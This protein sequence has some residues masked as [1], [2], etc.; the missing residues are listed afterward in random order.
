MKWYNIKTCLGLFL[1]QSALS[2]CQTALGTVALTVT[3]SAVSNTYQGPITLQVTGL[4]G[5]DSVVVQKFL[6]LNA[7]GTV[8]AADMLV[9]QFT[10]TDGQAGMVIGGV[11]NLNV[12]GDVDTAAGQITAKLRFP[13]GDFVQSIV[14]KYLFKVSGN[15]TPPLTND[16]T[17]T[18]FPYAQSIT[19]SVVSNNTST[20]IS[21]AVV[22]L[23]PSPRGGNHGPGNPVAAA[24]ADNSGNYH[25]QA[26][27]GTY[28]PLAF[29][30]NFVADYPT[31]PL[32]TLNGAQTIT[33][34]LTLSAAT[35][36]ISGQVVD[37]SNPGIGLPGIFLPAVSPSGLIAVAFP[38]TNG[39]FYA[40]VEPGTWNLEGAPAGL[41]LHG[42]VGY[43][44]GLNVSAGSSVTNGFPKATAL[45]YGR[46]TDELGNPLSAIDVYAN[47]NNGQFQSDGY[48]DTNGYYEV[49]ALGGLSGDG[50]YAEV[51]TGGGSGNPTNYI[52]SQPAFDQTGGASLSVNQ[53]VLVNFTA[54]V[55]TNVLSGNVQFGGTNVAGVGVFATA[56]IGGVTFNAY[57]DTDANGNYAF[58]VG[59][60]NWSVN[61]NCSGGNDSLDNI[62]G[63][64]TYQC[65]NN[66]NVTIN[67]NNAT[68]NFAV[69]PPG[70]SLQIST[71][72]L[73]NANVG[74]PYSAPL[75][76]SGGTMPYNWSLANGSLPLPSGLTLA[77]NGVI[78]GIPET[79]G[80]F[81]FTVQ[82]T[83]ASFSSANQSL[84]LIINPKPS[85]GAPSRFAGQF[86][87]LLSGGANQNYTIQTSTNLA[88]TNWVS[89]YV[90]NNPSSG[91]FVIRVPDATNSRGF[92]RIVVGP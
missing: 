92:Y 23:F 62:L 6:D 64:G 32:L 81:N 46:V 20:T 70:A 66:Q 43:Q 51:S 86:Q 24:V 42:Y 73:P 91:S 88:S 67:N 30:P 26:P 19:G 21:D 50:W 8:D 59:N 85:L 89:L 38:D 39:N 16:F 7:N 41:I 14:G 36:A 4:A 90:T 48:S 47:D 78:A 72:S 18:N 22:I 37:L 44:S 77:T 75:Q 53:A 27:T 15:F 74:A 1:I 68:A 29:G 54:L 11:T 57:A 52:F 17:V 79:N 55:A 35:A 25:I 3:P 60:G 49:G 80:L 65:P 2:L 83:D 76:A 33:T 87:F 56:T 5:G 12:P 84:G 9:Q 13:N 10:L 58:S 82:V 71:A 61:V 31:S 63:I 28:V 45:F 34:N 69:L 40:G